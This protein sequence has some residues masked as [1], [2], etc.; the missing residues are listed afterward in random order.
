MREIAPKIIEYFE[1]KG[2]PG[3]ATV[4]LCGVLLLVLSL[5]RLKSWHKLLYWEKWGLASQLFG[6][7]FATVIG[8]IFLLRRVL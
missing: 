3:E 6:S 5:K 4:T 1:S 7:I 2:I 8:S